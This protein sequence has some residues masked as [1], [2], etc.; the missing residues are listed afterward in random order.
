MEKKY[1]CN[2]CKKT[3]TEH[4]FHYSLNKYKKP[5]CNEH[6]SK[7]V[8]PIT[9]KLQDL[10]NKTYETEL[11]KEQKL[12]SIKVWINADFSKWQTQLNNKKHGRYLLK[13]NDTDKDKKRKYHQ[14]IKYKDKN[15]LKRDRKIGG[16]R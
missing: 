7:T 1:F 15:R 8:T 14:Y 13:E 9:N 4:M 10:V 11:Q 12:V 2:I 6:Q 16:G 5:L 3:I